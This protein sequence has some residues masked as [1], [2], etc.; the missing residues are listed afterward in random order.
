VGG[1]EGWPGAVMNR[2]RR[3]SGQDGAETHRPR[4]GKTVVEL[5]VPAGG[6]AWRRRSGKRLYKED[7]TVSRLR[8]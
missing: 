4:A 3:S 2:R 8:I 6:A 5:L 1:L 7:G